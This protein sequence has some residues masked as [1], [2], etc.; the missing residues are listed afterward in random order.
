MAR[1]APTYQRLGLMTRSMS[2]PT[3]FA[4]R[5]SL[6][7]QKNILTAIDNMYAKV[8]K[9]AAIEAE[10][11][12]IEYGA[13]N[14][15]TLEQIEES[16]LRGQDVTQKFDTSTI[17]GR[18]ARESALG[19]LD[20][21]LTYEGRTRFAQLDAELRAGRVDLTEYAE[22]MNAVTAGLSG[23]AQEASPALAA[24]IRAE[25]GVTAASYFQSYG[26][27]VQKKRDVQFEA[28]YAVS[29]NGARQAI[30][31]ELEGV[32]NT[33]LLAQAD[34]ETI[35]TYINQFKKKTYT[36][37]LTKAYEGQYS[38][39]KITTLQDN[40]NQDIETALSSFVLNKAQFQ[41]DAGEF[42][43]M[44]SANKPTGNPVVDNIVGS[45][46]N[47]QRLATASQIQEIE[48]SRLGDIDA[49]DARA[50]EINTERANQIKG[51]L[52]IALKEH[53]PT[54]GPIRDI[55]AF[56]ELLEE[57]RL[58]DPN[59]AFDIIDAGYATNFGQNRTDDG[60]KQALQIAYARN[61]LSIDDVI[62]NIDNLNGEDLVDFTNKAQSLQNKENQIALSFV[63]GEID[64]NED[65]Q[66]LS[67]DDP[68]YKLSQLYAQI[69]GNLHKASLE[70][71]NEGADFDAMV[72]AQSELDLLGEEIKTVIK[73]KA[74]K[75]GTLA[76][77]NINSIL[78][79]NNT[80]TFGTMEE[81]LDYLDGL[82]S[83]KDFFG[84]PFTTVSNYKNKIE[85]AL[86]VQ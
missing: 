11:K 29:I 10:Y 8:S 79:Q 57:L 65:V 49:A 31:R 43:S 19:V 9:S 63:A 70:A 59:S 34:A 26:A 78:K 41:D 3:D 74:V 53:N 16:A 37:I 68:N 25:L 72:F 58:I 1:E 48:R 84:I 55:P 75:A 85:K 7:L 66:N 42:A 64:F 4:A 22:Q 32:L 83:G 47:A 82:A 21:E 51:N 24:K 6:A 60:V 76:L 14:P 69:K 38:A 44:V 45:M 20:N 71:A 17:F 13:E 81:A 18:A 52:L 61:E 23:A 46:T 77:K 67:E 2:R 35:S 15:I 27:E 33:P 39:T 28:S 5:E 50:D 36:S 86:E 30:P 12:G 54:E 62:A 56:S 80:Q 73:E 40:I